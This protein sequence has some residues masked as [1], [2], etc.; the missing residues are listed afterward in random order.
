MCA[1]KMVVSFNYNLLF[2]IQIISRIVQLV[3]VY[4]GKINMDS[5]QFQEFLQTTKTA[6]QGMLQHRNNIVLV[7]HFEPIESSKEK[8]QQC[9]EIFENYLRLKNV[10]DNKK[11]CA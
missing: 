5:N 3:G 9:K 11:V 2:L 8:F 10:F 7:S 1:D 4:R 6:F